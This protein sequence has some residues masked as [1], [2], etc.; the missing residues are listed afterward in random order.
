M[1]KDL[2]PAVHGI[3][4]GSN[5]GLPEIALDQGASDHL[6]LIAPWRKQVQQDRDGPVLPNLEG[7]DIVDEERVWGLQSQVPREAGGPGNPQ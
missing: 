4:C 3:Q 1:R 7:G 6:L 5:T 2:K